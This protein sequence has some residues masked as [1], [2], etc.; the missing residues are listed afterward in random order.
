[1]NKI[2][3]IIF[4]YLVFFSSSCGGDDDGL[5][6]DPAPDVVENETKKEEIE[7]ENCPEGP[8]RSTQKERKIPDP[9]GVYLPTGEKKMANQCMQMQMV[10]RCSTTVQLGDYRS[11]GEVTSCFSESINEEW[12]RGELE[13]AVIRMISL[14]R[15]PFSG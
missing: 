7:P 12:S 8:C 15:I 10:S 4:C 11:N 9:N 1:M 14:L 13:F 2:I 5:S 6:N 3:I